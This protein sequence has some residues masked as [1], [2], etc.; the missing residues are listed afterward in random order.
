MQHSLICVN[1]PN[2]SQFEPA[3]TMAPAPKPPPDRA[4]RRLIGKDCSVPATPGDIELLGFWADAGEPRGWGGKA[5]PA[6][7]RFP[8]RGHRLTSCHA[9]ENRPLGEPE[10]NAD[11]ESGFE[12]APPGVERSDESGTT[13]TLIRGA[14][15][16][17]VSLGRSSS[18]WA[19]Y[20]RAISAKRRDSKGAWGSASTRK[21]SRRAPAVSPAL[22]NSSGPQL[23]PLCRDRRRDPTPVLRRALADRHHRLAARRPSRCR[24]PSTAPRARSPAATA[25]PA[26]PD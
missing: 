7:A 8:R 20:A 5:S 22:S 13:G 11:A 15:A 21:A 9:G 23:R 6:Q 12:G 26:A 24:P 19:A 17:A 25:T 3:R 4:L 18:T 1:I 16:A 2:G 14:R 10:G